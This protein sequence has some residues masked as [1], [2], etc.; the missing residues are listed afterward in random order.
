MGRPL[1]ARSVRLL[2]VDR[3][4][5][6]K[7]AAPAHGSMG[8]VKKQQRAAAADE[9]GCW[10]PHPRT[11]IYYPKGHDWVMEDV[12]EGASSFP[13]TY[14]LRRDSFE[15][16]DKSDA[17]VSTRTNYDHPFLGI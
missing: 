6:N 16:V 8:R 17:D 1:L 10:V 14:W 12:P 3:G 4:V 2:S 15:D 11:G 9:E 13:R 7:H 5:R